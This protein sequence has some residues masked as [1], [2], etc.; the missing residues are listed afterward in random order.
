[1]AK[2]LGRIIRIIGGA[3]IIW[4]GSTMGGGAGAVV[5]VLGIIPVLAGIFNL[6]M[7]SPFIRVPFKGEDILALPDTE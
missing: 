7:I 6:C 5:V 4:W 3:A 1:M 2:P